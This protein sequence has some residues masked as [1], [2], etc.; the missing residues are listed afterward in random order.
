MLDIYPRLWIGDDQDYLKMKDKEGWAFVRAAKYGPG[1]HQQMLGYTSRGA[2]KG[3]NYYAVWQGNHLAL[4]LIDSDDPAFFH[5]EA[6]NPALEFID[7]YLKAGYNV[8]VSCNRGHSRSPSIVFLY[9]GMIHDLPSDFNEAFRVF[10]ILYPKYD[11][12]QGIKFYIKHH[13]K[14]VVGG[15]DLVPIKE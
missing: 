3:P 4:N 5:E 12:G 6:I 7:K 2:P 1:G 10:K 14:A 13:Y 8:L 15:R 11:P 9:L